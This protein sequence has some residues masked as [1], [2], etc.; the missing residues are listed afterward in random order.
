[1]LTCANGICEVNWKPVKPTATKEVNNMNLSQVD[2]VKLQAKYPKMRLIAVENF[3]SGYNSLTFEASMNLSQDAR[4]YKWNSDT[5]N[6]IK[7][8]LNGKFMK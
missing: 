4:A 5:V 6:A 3:C 7:A 1:M 2:F 8:V